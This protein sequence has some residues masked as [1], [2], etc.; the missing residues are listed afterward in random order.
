VDRYLIFDLGTSYFKACLF[1][2]QGALLGVHR[3]PSPIEYFADG[4]AEMAPASL[5]KTLVA[6]TSQLRLELG[7]LGDVAAISFA[8]Q[9]NSFTLLDQRDEPL[10]PLVIWC[11]ARAR[12]NS[13][14]L[15]ELARTVDYYDTTGISHLDYQFM[16]AKLHWLA[17]H[18]P[19][20][21]DRSC[22]IA[23]ISDYLTLWMTG[24]L[25]TEASVAWLTGLVDVHEGT[26]WPDAYGVQAIPQAW[27]PEI[28]RAGA[29]LGP[30]LPSV[31]DE[32][33]A[34]RDCHFVVGCLDQFAGAIGA[35]NVLPGSV[36]E[37]TGT[38]L[39][40]V[41]CSSRFQR[42]LRA[43]A[44]QGPASRRGEYYQMVFGNV[45][46][47]LL[48]QYRNRLPD[49]P[50]FEQLDQWATDAMSADGL[51][52]DLDAFAESGECVLR[53]RRTGHTPG[54]EVYAILET[55]ADSLATQ[56][57][58]LCA[59]E[60]PRSV[61][62]AGGAARS[63]LWRQIKSEKLGCPVVPTMCE[64]PTSLGAAMLAHQSLRGSSLEQLSR[65]WI[66][67]RD[68]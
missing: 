67:T 6:A 41:R 27:L 5:R 10:L 40:T 48:E 25:V 3:L 12:G 16:P 22:K 28:V 30:L 59:A 63:G 57:A 54:N 20:I 42:D 17:R 2:D 35:G 66:R 60:P 37:T 62:S 21:L 61:R 39:A 11:D 1:D 50:T 56:V 38:V 19:T 36:S 33:G 15:E 29:D 9:A 49:R 32:L 45:S 58:T 51:A 26:W 43:R 34:P 64:E 53:N 24:R 14:P 68:G 55:V 13:F 18:E 23:S 8:S 46:A 31:A 44:F 4:R 65:E 7:S 52:V 47:A